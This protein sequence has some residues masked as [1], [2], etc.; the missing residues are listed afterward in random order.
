[1]AYEVHV[2]RKAKRGIWSEWSQTL[3]A[4]AEICDP[5]EVQWS[6]KSIAEKGVRLLSIEVSLGPAVQSKLLGDVMYNVSVI[7][8][9]CE[10]AVLLTN[11]TMHVL[12][13][14]ES[15]VNI[16]VIAFNNVSQSPLIH[17]TVP[18]S[19][20][21]DFHP[22]NFQNLTIRK[23]NYCLEWYDATK[24]RENSSWTKPGDLTLLIK[25]VNAWIEDNKLY[26]LIVHY[27]GKNGWRTKWY[28][29][30][31]KTEGT[32]SN[33]PRNVS[34]SN[35]TANSASIKWDHIPIAQRQGFLQHY[36]INITGGH[37]TA[38]VEVTA[39]ET[40]YTF[41]NLKA[42][43]AYEVWIAGKTRIGNGKQSEVTQ[44]STLQ[45]PPSK[46]QNL[47]L[48]IIAPT[49]ILLLLFTGLR[50]AVKRFKTALLPAVPSPVSTE[51]LT[52][53][54][55]KTKKEMLPEKEEVHVGNLEVIQEKSPRCH[56]LEDVDLLELCEIQTFEEETD[57]LS[58]TG[59]LADSGFL[60]SPNYK[61]Q[62]LNFPAVEPEEEEEPTEQSENII[63]YGKTTCEALTPTYKNSLVFDIES[64][65]DCDQE[66]SS[67]L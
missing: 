14:S 39:S 6:T 50:F 15:A 61:R 57:T 44:F 24:T 66:S 21:R 17:I 60:V 52:I 19:D 43:T 32:P 22:E 30:Y 20:P 54:Y 7:K 25:N 46:D 64:K 62:M 16:S 31:Y 2:R 38:Q 56:P 41:T 13:V 1:M 40:N 51:A 3:M 23:K 18:A 12:N 8:V 11:N 9:P 49:V 53:T 36:V 55:M 67:V 5:P 47:V 58:E 28:W 42:A 10:E 45:G 29:E 63:S 4:P 65:Q 37:H 26:R 59:C 27:H 34:V 35:I 33:G 48:W